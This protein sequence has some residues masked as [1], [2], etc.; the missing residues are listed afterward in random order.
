MNACLGKGKKPFPRFVFNPPRLGGMKRHFLS[1]VKGLDRGIFE[2]VA[3]CPEGPLVKEAR[4][5]RG[6]VISLPSGNEFS[7]LSPWT[8][9]RLVSVLKKEKPAILHAHGFRAGLVGRLATSVSGTPAVF[10]TVHG[11][12][13]GGSCFGRQYLAS[14]VENLLSKVTDRV[15]AVSEAIRQ[16]LLAKAGLDS[17]K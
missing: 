10:I 15:I 12:L 17:K 11:S 1:L 9:A 13:G 2:P 7:F 5:C 16:E 14:L 6:R 4:L 3:V 8:D